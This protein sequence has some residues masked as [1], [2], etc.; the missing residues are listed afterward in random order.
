MA[1]LLDTMA[2]AL[3]DE[4]AVGGIAARLKARKHALV[5]AACSY[6]EREQWHRVPF[7]HSRPLSGL[8]DCLVVGPAG[9]GG[10]RDKPH[11]GSI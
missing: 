10:T 4:A 2:T 11:P 7:I 5:C 3:S 1:S 9:Q 8:R 6:R